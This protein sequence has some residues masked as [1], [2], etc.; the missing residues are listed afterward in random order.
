MY[1]ILCGLLIKN[2]NKKP[3]GVNKFK[4]FGDTDKKKEIKDL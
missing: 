1:L 3:N 2:K 4:F